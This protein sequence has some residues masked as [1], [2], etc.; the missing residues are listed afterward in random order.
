MDARKGNLVERPT[1]TETQ[2]LY[3]KQFELRLF[4]TGGIFGAP[5]GD[6]I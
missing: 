6:I 4:S 1:R 3:F 5:W 2:K